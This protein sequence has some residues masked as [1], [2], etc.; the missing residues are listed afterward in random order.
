MSLVIQPDVGL[1]LA[2]DAVERAQRAGADAAKATHSYVE[3]FEVNFDTTDISLVRSTVTDGL[4]ITVFRG[5]RKGAAEVTGRDHDT[6]DAAIGQALRAAEASQPDPA[7][8]LPVEQAEPAES[9][10]DTEPDREEMVDVVSGFLDW[11][12][13]E[14]PSILSRASNYSF[15][16]TFSSYANAHGRTQHARRS[17]YSVTLV[18][19]GRH[20]RSSTSFQYT[21]VATAGPATDIAGLGAIR[22]CIDETESSFDARPVPSTFVGDVILTPAALATFVGTVATSLGGLA[23]MKGTTPYLERMGER[24]A[25][26]VFSLLHRPGRLAAAPSFD[27]EGFPNRDLDV[28]QDGVLRNFLVDWYMSHKLGRPMTSGHA[29]L[30]VAAGTSTFDDIVAATERGIVVGRFSGGVPNQNLDFSG[31]AKNSFYVEDG[32]VVG[33]VNE[34]MVAGNLGDVLAGIKAI[35]AERI[36][37][38]FT[39]MPWVAAGGVTISTR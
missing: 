11:L 32:K 39:L 13:R 26:P 30:E 12:N 4:T 28:V 23:L 33:P 36:D 2:R 14:H 18:V 37:S 7:N 17:H 10:G 20:E 34:T 9:R 29:D 24:V 22:Q 8:V 21:T 6:V 1:S 3:R 19:A 15:V 16:N 5:D 38:G 25:A 35:S 31:V 27:A